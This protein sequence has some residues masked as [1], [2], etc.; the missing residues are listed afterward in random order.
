VLAHLESLRNTMD[1]IYDIKPEEINLKTNNII[2]DIILVLVEIFYFL[3][4]FFGFSSKLI[5]V[6]DV[7]R[8]CIFCLI[9]FYFLVIFFSYLIV[10]LGL[11]IKIVSTYD[12]KWNKLIG[13][14]GCQFKLDEKIK[15]LFDKKEKK[16]VIPNLSLFSYV[17]NPLLEKSYETI[18]NKKC[19]CC[20][21]N[22]WYKIKNFCML[23]IFLASIIISIWICVV[24]KIFW[25]IL[26]YFILFI[27]M[28]ILSLM[29]NFPFL[30]RNKKTNN[31]CDFF[32]PKTIYNDQYK[33]KHPR[34]V[35]LIRLICFS[36]CLI[37]SGVLIYTFFNF[38]EDTDFIKNFIKKTFTPV[39][40]RSLNI[41]LP[42][43]CYSP[44]HN[45]NLSLY[46]PFIND[47]YYFD[48]KT[49]YSSFKKV[50][51]KRMFFNDKY[52]IEVVGN[53]IEKDSANNKV[54]MIQYNVVT[55]NSHQITILSIKGT[56]HKKDVYL[57]I[58]LYF[59]SVLLNLFSLFSVF[60]QQK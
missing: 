30:I 44:I 1:I 49:A 50:D 45:M 39:K 2:F 57:D 16:E 37:I 18:D 6:K 28:H 35:S 41:L 60:S 9:Y 8:V 55:P 7:I 25:N 56:S 13:L 36:I 58:Q 26:F 38:E 52:N 29:V 14:F 42:N 47:A 54:K 10:S 4:F 51:Y 27:F 23:I 3:G 43:I 5:I 59:P 24:H 20:S 19:C 12:G 17:I 31:C 48:D 15:F 34:M 32:S 33:M 21:N 40:E 53:L 46:L 22:F 11:Y